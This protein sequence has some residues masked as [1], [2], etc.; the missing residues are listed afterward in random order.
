MQ[1]ERLPFIAI[2]KDVLQKSKNK[3]LLPSSHLQKRVGIG[4]HATTSIILGS[5]P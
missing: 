5:M 2:R 4:G 1:I 3:Q